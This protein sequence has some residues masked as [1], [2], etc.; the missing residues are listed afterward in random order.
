MNTKKLKAYRK[1]N[2]VNQSDIANL[3]NI[4]LTSYSHKEN[5][6]TKFTLEEAKTISDFFG[7]SIEEIFFNNN[8]NLKFTETVN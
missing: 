2:N 4:T 1:L 8:V 7:L 5:G 3:L 6:K